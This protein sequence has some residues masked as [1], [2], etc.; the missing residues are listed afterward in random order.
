[1]WTQTLLCS[2]TLATEVVIEMWNFETNMFRF[3]TTS[4]IVVCSL[5]TWSVFVDEQKNTTATDYT[6][7]PD[8]VVEEW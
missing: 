4:S 5:T 7:L 1:M 6:F 8:Y 2:Q 3:G